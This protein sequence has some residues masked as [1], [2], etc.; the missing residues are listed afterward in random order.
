MTKIIIPAYEL[1]VECDIQIDPLYD[2]HE[3]VHVPDGTCK[4]Q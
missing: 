1:P 2:S 3:T 4:L